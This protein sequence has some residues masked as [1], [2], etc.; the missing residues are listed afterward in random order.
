MGLNGFYLL[1]DDEEQAL[2][3]PYG[4]H[5]IPL[6]VSAKQY[7]ANGSLVYNTHNNT[8]LWGDVIEV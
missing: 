3:L 2:D 8:G 6:A 1:S 4:D 5:D 7:A